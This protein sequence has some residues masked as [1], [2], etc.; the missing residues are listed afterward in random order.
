MIP[1]RPARHSDLLSP[2]LLNAATCEILSAPEHATK[3]ESSHSLP[4][5]N[6]PGFV[7]GAPAVVAHALHVR[8]LLVEL[9]AALDCEAFECLAISAPIR[10]HVQEGKNGGYAGFA[11]C[12]EEVV[13]KRGP[14]VRGCDGCYGQDVKFAVSYVRC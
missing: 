1:Q 14:A 12:F 9:A 3:Q 5:V 2:G 13:R 6:E 4:R 8:S 11:D 7:H 10:E